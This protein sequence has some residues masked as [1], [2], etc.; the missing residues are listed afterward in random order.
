[1]SSSYVSKH[2]E[3]EFNSLIAAQFSLDVLLSAFLTHATGSVDSNFVILYMVT[4]A[5]GS[6][7]LPR[8]HALALASGAIIALFHRAL[9]QSMEQPRQH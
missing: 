1:M 8:K 5:T 2:R 9:L 3:M 4:V 6:V 7:V